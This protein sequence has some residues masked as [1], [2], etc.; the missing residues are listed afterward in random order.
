MSPSDIVVLL[1][2][3]IWE[4]EFALR[5][6]LTPGERLSGTARNRQLSS[7]DRILRRLSERGLEV[8]ARSDIQEAGQASEQNTATLTLAQT[9]PKV[10]G[11]DP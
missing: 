5:Q 8:S 2:K 6:R 9:V 11:Q 1:A 10:L 4:G 7:A 3:I